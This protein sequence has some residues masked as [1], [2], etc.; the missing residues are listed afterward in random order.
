MA[1]VVVVV[2]GGSALV[3]AVVTLTGLIPPSL[4]ATA[5]LVVVSLT[6]IKAQTAAQPSAADV[7]ALRRKLARRQTP[8]SDKAT[9]PAAPVN[10]DLIR[11][12]RDDTFLD[13]YGQLG[14]V[15]RSL[16]ALVLRDF[17]ESWYSMVSMDDQREDSDGADSGND[18]DDGPWSSDPFLSHLG[19]VF[20]TVLF[21]LTQAG[22]RLNRQSF[23]LRQTLSIFTQ[24]FRHFRA[25][26]QRARRVASASRANTGDVQRTI[27]ELIVAEWDRAAVGDKRGGAGVK[28]AGR[29]HVAAYGEEE[30]LEYARLVCRSIVGD[31]LRGDG[32]VVSRE[33]SASSVS[34]TLSGDARCSPL[35]QQLVAEIVAQ[36][37][38]IP[39]VAACDGSY[40]EDY[41]IT[42]QEEQQQLRPPPPLPGLTRSLSANHADQPPTSTATGFSTGIFQ[43]LG[44]TRLSGAGGSFMAMDT[45]SSS[46][47]WTHSNNSPDRR[48]RAVSEMA[49]PASAV[50]PLPPPAA[51]PTTPLFPMPSMVDSP[52]EQSDEAAVRA[53]EWDMQ[54]PEHDDC[55]C[56]EVCPCSE[57][58][59]QPAE[60]DNK[61]AKA[62]VLASSSSASWMGSVTQLFASWAPSAST[63][64]AAGTASQPTS[65]GDATDA[66]AAAA[67][68]TA[69]VQPRLSSPIPPLL[70]TLQT[71]L[72]LKAQPPAPSS[73]R[74][75]RMQEVRE[76]LAMLLRTRPPLAQLQAAGVHRWPSRDFRASVVAFTRVSSFVDPHVE[77]HVRVHTSSKE[78]V[79]LRRYSEFKRLY[80]ALVRAHPSVRG[81]LRVPGR[82]PLQRFWH[83]KQAAVRRGQELEDFMQALLSHPLLGGS[84]PCAELW[85]FLSATPSDVRI[86][87][88]SKP[89]NTIPLTHATHHLPPLL[90]TAEA[91][92]DHN[93]ATSPVASQDVAKHEQQGGA[94]TA[95]HEG[96]ESVSSP[97]CDSLR[98]L[99][100]GCSSCSVSGSENHDGGRQQVVGG[101]YSEGYDSDGSFVVI[102]MQDFPSVSA[103]TPQGKRQWPH[104][105]SSEASTLPESPPL[106][107]I[108]SSMTCCPPEAPLPPPPPSSPVANPL[109]SPTGVP[110]STW[111]VK[112]D[113]MGTPPH[114][115]PLPLD[116]SMSESD[117]LSRV[118]GAL[119]P[120]D[121]PLAAPVRGTM[122]LSYS[123]SSVSSTSTSDPAASSE[124][125]GGLGV[126]VGDARGRFT[127]SSS[128][129]DF[130]L[131]HDLEDGD[132]DIL[133]KWLRVLEAREL[134]VDDVEEKLMLVEW[135]RALTCRERFLYKKEKSLLRLQRSHQPLH[136]SPSMPSFPPS[137]VRSASASDGHRDICGMAGVPSPYTRDQLRYARH[138]LGRRKRLRQRERVLKRRER[139][140]MA[141]QA[142]YVSQLEA[143]DPSL[144]NPLFALLEEIFAIPQATRGAH[145]FTTGRSANDSQRTIRLL[146]LHQLAFQLLAAV[147]KAPISRLV[148]RHLVLWTSQHSIGRLLSQCKEV[149]WPRGATFRPPVVSPAADERAAVKGRKL[150]LGQA[151]DILHQCVVPESVVTQRVISRQAVV[152][153]ILDVY[154]FVTHP[155]LLTNLAFHVF[156]CL[157][158]TLFPHLTPHLFVF[159]HRPRQQDD[160][161]ST[162]RSF[163][164]RRDIF[165][166]PS[167]SLTPFHPPTFGAGR[168]R[169][170]RLMPSVVGHR[171]HRVVRRQRQKGQDGPTR[172][173]S[174]SSGAKEEERGDD[175]V[176]AASVAA[177]RSSR[178]RGGAAAETCSVVDREG[179][180]GGDASLQYVTSR[181]MPF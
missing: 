89:P 2:G 13:D 164:G 155:V 74:L 168:G 165:P 70:S 67:G 181:W 146:T 124:R 178:E 39:L 148:R 57:H 137:L 3:Y 97:A 153:G 159:A 106:H 85:R 170:H 90:E 44:L 88:G 18:R 22:P 117:H 114:T 56:P 38:V 95:N 31:L 28:G 134:Q 113:P 121:S 116:R 9:P 99:P 86:A 93:E 27:D 154:E 122:P 11:R 58:G 77:F 107:I 51:P 87:M 160:N 179:I 81:G 33:S 139:S 59:D 171:E 142:A 145:A 128:S 150:S 162:S 40:L 104:P 55:T 133:T 151:R 20:N 71:L 144:L 166:S 79:V 73:L 94:D 163:D 48:S 37:I 15:L 52:D 10:D 119:T 8:S 42:L 72:P 174:S 161:S 50:P 100:L 45:G 98:G 112:E 23:I 1:L 91:E 62:E 115:S 103:P 177:D 24:H 82:H 130:D 69:P 53:G 109:A 65:G 135:Q 152:E 111:S 19:G 176:V 120:P 147:V 157:V 49:F 64:A 172:D 16:K 7:A 5:L 54:T 66:P 76:K 60:G 118:G 46:G 126:G 92:A 75:F 84:P 32:P 25:V 156:D 80:A 14:Q 131:V 101:V 63:T 105:S 167:P 110:L 149:L 21:N 173:D 141:R 68:P 123:F 169:R 175:N 4:Y 12:S 78:W 26:R 127:C 35:V 129:F 138:Q 132:P 36:N 43:L 140:L 29:L 47:C 41:L 34:G 158:A 61:G 143:Q 136:M 83:P 96:Q 102:T 125:E 6:S 17:V 108:A 30:Q 180:G